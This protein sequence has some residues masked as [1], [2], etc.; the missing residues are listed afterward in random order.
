M[1]MEMKLLKIERDERKHSKKYIITKD[2]K[3]N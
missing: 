1:D 3:I 2:E